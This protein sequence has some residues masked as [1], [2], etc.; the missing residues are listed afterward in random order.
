MWRCVIS[1][2]Y[3]CDGLFL[4][5]NKALSPP[6][7]L[8]HLWFADL[9]MHLYIL[10][11]PSVE[12][13]PPNIRPNL[14]IHYGQAN[15]MVRKISSAP[16]LRRQQP[17]REEHDICTKL[18]AHS[19]LTHWKMLRLRKNENHISIMVRIRFTRA[20]D[21][22]NRDGD[23]HMSMSRIIVMMVYHGNNASVHP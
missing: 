23:H 9:L 11:I 12:P 20:F 18:I 22:S 16:Q 19:S 10:C 17:M 13:A 6:I 8:C 21:Y 14:L 1:R 5:E 2:D 3:Q 4:L 7:S 15:A